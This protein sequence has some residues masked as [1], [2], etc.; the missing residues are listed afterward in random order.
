MI[1]PILYA[2]YMDGLMKRLQETGVGSYMGLRYNVAFVYA[3][4][5]TFL[6]PY[7]S[8]L[9][10]LISGVYAAEY[11]IILFIGNM[12]LLLCFKGRFCKVC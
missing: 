3:D 2:V 6:S 5:L 1:S 10:V 4:D 11:D 12:S 9:S 7:R 8:L